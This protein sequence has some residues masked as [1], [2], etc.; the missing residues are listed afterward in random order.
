MAKQASPKAKRS[1]PPKFQNLRTS[2]DLLRHT[3]ATLAYRA[4]KVLRDV[5]A[6][7]AAFRASPSCRTPLEILAH[8][9]DLMEWAERLAQGEY[10]WD[11]HVAGDWESETERFF[12]KLKALDR[13]IAAARAA[14]YPPDTIFQGPVA[15][16]LTH[17]GQ[18]A[19]LR[20]LFGAAVRPEA[21]ARAT[22]RVGRVGRSQPSKRVEFDGDASQPRRRG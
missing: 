13:A 15:D 16:A 8:L 14:A 19:M 1:Q 3:V 22:I 18:L 4:E 11:P 17:V 10:R 12:K 7:F 2:R 20:G 21:Y 6:G 9:G 5:P